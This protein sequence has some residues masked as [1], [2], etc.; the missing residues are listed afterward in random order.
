MPFSSHHLQGT[1]LT[2]MMFNLIT[3]DNV[4][5]VTI[6]QS[7]TCFPLSIL[8]G[9]KSLSIAFTGQGVNSHFFEGVFMYRDLSLLSIYS[10]SYHPQIHEYLFFTYIMH[11]YIF[12]FQLVQALV[13]E[14]SLS[15]LLSPFDFITV[16]CFCSFSGTT[17]YPRLISDISCLN[18]RI[19]HFSKDRF[20]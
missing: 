1:W 10:F 15:W 9:N 6:L 14:T 19:S 16:G 11:Y 3:W 17:K 20:L 2:P 5:Q 12:W 4:C 13:I 8:F 7:Y 18:L